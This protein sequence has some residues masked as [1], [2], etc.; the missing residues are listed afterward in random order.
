MIIQ[1]LKDV[2]QGKTTL[3]SKRSS[4]WPTVRKNHLKTNPTC[5]VCNGSEKVEVHHIKPF[6]EHPELELDATNLI[7]LCESKSYGIVCHLAVGHL[8]HYRKTNEDV[9]KD[10]NF[11]NKKLS[12]ELC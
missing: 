4:K 5:A 8:G 11:W 7:T 3:K 6:H 9:I 2:V 12:K 1:H 10:A